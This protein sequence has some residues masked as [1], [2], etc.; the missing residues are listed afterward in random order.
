MRLQVGQFYKDDML[1]ELN[2]S[3]IGFRGDSKEEETKG[4]RKIITTGRWGCGAYNGHPELKFMLQWI[5]ASAHGREMIFTTFQEK[6]CYRIKELIEKFKG[7]PISE[8]FVILMNLRGFIAKKV[9]I[10]KIRWN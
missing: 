9:S 8:L 6:D 2:K 5:A 7:K 10:L 3:F 1:R 4:E